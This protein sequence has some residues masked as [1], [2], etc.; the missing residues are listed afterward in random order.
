MRPFAYASP[1]TADEI[2]ALLTPGSAGADGASRP[3]AGGTDLLTLMKADVATPSRLVDIKGAGLPKGIEE[4]PPGL[5]VGG[6]TTLAQIETHPAVRARYPA[7]AE[8]TA[9]AATAQLRNV[10]TVAGNLLQR[11]RCWY[12]R[13]PRIACWLKGGDHCPARDGENQLHAILGGGPCHA[14]HP[15]DVAPALVALDADARLRGPGG[16]RTVPVEGLF[17]APEDGRRRETLVGSDELLLALRLPPADG[18]RSTYLKSMDRKVWAFA[19]A[20]VA[21]R[22]RLDGRR[23]AEARIVLGGVAPVPWR[24]HE[25]ERALEGAEAGPAAWDRAA[26]AALADAAPLRHNAYKLPLA[27]ALVR[28]ALEKLAT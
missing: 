16:E 7:L 24:A 12:F 18:S 17:A 19:L 23:V 13:N 4:T 20:G 22:L 9:V 1:R 27:R 28:R 26:N 11:P 2:I 8:A 6:L 21:A 10:A 14:V 15:S 5:V 25:A 3:L